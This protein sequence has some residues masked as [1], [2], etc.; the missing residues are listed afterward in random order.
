M[1]RRLGATRFVIGLL[2]AAS[3]AFAVDAAA[4]VVPAA[5]LSINSPSV[6]EGDSGSTNLTFTV[7]LDPTSASQVT[8]D[9]ADA[10]T[11]TATSGTDYTALTAGTLTFAAGVSSQ[12]ITVSVTGDTTHES[13]ETVE[14]T[15]SN[16]TNAT[17]STTAGTG[18]GTIRDDENPT[19]TVNSPTVTEGDSGSTNMTFTVSLSPASRQRVRVVFGITG[20]TA[21]CGTDYT[22]TLNCSQPRVRMTFNPGETSRTVTLAVQGDTTA[23]A[24]EETVL[25][26]LSG[27]SFGARIGTGTGTGTITDDDQP[28]L[29]LNSPS[30]TEG[31]SGSTDMTFTV[32]MSAASTAQVTVGYTD[33]GGTAT[34]TSGTDYEALS[35]G[36]LTFAPGETSKTITVK[37]TGDTDPE[38]DE[39]VRVALSQTAVTNAVVPASGRLGV[40]TITDD[41]LA[42]LRTGPASVTEGDSGSVSLTFTVTLVAAS[43]AQVT[44][45]YADAGT[46][47][48]TSGTDYT[49]V[50]AGTLTIAAG[51][52]SGTITVSVTG[53]TEAETPETVVL[54]LSNPTNARFLTPSMATMT[55][56]IRDDDNFP[57]SNAGPDQTVN[58]GDTVNLSGSGSDPD[59]T[60][61]TYEW[62]QTDGPVVTLTGATTTTPS[63]TA[64]TGLT[65]DTVLRF[66]LVVTSNF[67]GTSDSVDITVD[68]A[69]AS[70]TASAGTDQTVNEGDTVNLSGTGPTLQGVGQ[71]RFSWR[72]TGGGSSTVSLTRAD[73]ARPTFTAPNLLADD[74]LTITLTVTVGDDTVTDT[75]DVTVR[76]DNDPP[77]AD[78]GS[79]RLAYG[80]TQVNLQGSGSDPEGETLSYSWSQTAGEPTV[81]LTGATTATPSFIAPLI[82]SETTL[83]FMLT[84]TAGGQ[85]ATDTVNVRLL[86]GPM[87]DAGANQT[88]AESD[89]VSLD[90]RGSTAPPGESL[91][92]SWSQTGGSPAVSLTGGT[93][94]T[95]SFTAP[96]GLSAD[97]TLTF[98]LTVTL[99]SGA[100]S[101][102]DTVE[103]T[104]TAA[105]VFTPPP[106]VADAG[107]DQTVQGGQLVT[108]D[109]SGSTE[110][111]SYSWSQ[112]GGGPPVT[113]TNVITATPSFVAPLGLPDDITLTFTLT[114]TG[115]TGS[116]TDTVDVTVLGGPIFT[117]IPLTADAGPDQTVD[118]GDAV[119]L[120]GS[121]STAPE[122]ETLSYSWSQTGGSPTVTLTGETT[123][124]PSF[125]APDLT[126]DATLTFTL[127]VTVGAESA[128][129]TV[130]VTVSA[131]PVIADAGPDQTVDEGDAVSLDGSGSTA[132]PGEALSYAWRQTGGSP[133]VTLTGETTATPSFTA[134]NLTADATLTFTLT[135]TAGADNATDTVAVMVQADNDAPTANAG[136]D[137][138]VYEGDSVNLSG[139]GSDPEGEALS[140]AWSQTNGDPTVTLTDATT[141]TPSFTAP[142]VSADVTLTFTLTVTAGGD[143][144]TDTVDVAIS[145]FPTLSID[146]SSVAEGDADSTSLT[147]TVSLSAESGRQVTVAYATADGTA[148]AGSDYQAASGEVQ[149]TPGDTELTV[150][151]PV[152]GDTTPEA[153]ETFTL[154]LSSPV[155]AELSRAQ[156]TA[157]IV[158]DDTAQASVADARAEEGD[159]G[160]RNIDF[161]VTLSTASDIQVTVAYATADG[162]A[163][164]GTDYRATNG[165]L[166]FAPGET[167]LTVSVPVLGDTTPEGDETFTLALSGATNAELGRAATGVIVDDDM[168]EARDRALEASLAGFGRTLTWDAM[169][170]ISG[171]F[172]ETP[173]AGGS[174]MTLGG[175]AAPIGGNLF[176]NQFADERMAPWASEAGWS[177]TVQAPG[178]AG[179]HHSTEPD[180]HG[181][182][183]GQL[184]LRDFL[185]RSSFDLALAGSDEG[186]EG[187]HLS[188]WG[189]ASSGRFSGEPAAGL[190]SDGEVATGYL[191]LDAKV[192]ERLLAGVALAHSD[193]EMGYGISD[194]GGKLDVSLTS[195]L[196]Y[197]HFQ[198]SEELEIWS[199]VGLGW[200]DGAF[201]DAVQVG[202][203]AQHDTRG[204]LD[205]GFSMAA[206]GA[207]RALAP[208]RNVDLELKSD[209]FV[210]FMEGDPEGNAAQPEV[211]ARSQGLRLTLAGRQE[212]M[213]SEQGRLGV[214]VEFGGRWDGGDAQTGW[215]AEIGGGLDYRHADLGLQVAVRGQYLLVHSARSFDEKGVSVTLE[216]D[217]GVQG[218]GLSLALRPAWGANPSGAAAMWNNEALLRHGGTAPHTESGAASE[219]LDLEWGYGFGL[220]E[221]AGLLRLRGALSNQGM[222]Q[223]GYRF[224]GVLDLS[225][226]TRASLELNRLEGLGK[227]SHGLL[228]EW[229]HTW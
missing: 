160:T 219:R 14:I 191:G 209:A 228:I 43:G 159:S 194:F 71:P 27:V 216:F 10:G 39:T 38:A 182:G 178:F 64:P 59:G 120:D 75:V 23:E 129:D 95:P 189:R 158:N 124:T 207:N 63:F 197:V 163:S 171:R 21:T 22:T 61:V 100:D 18:T 183:R 126:E 110:A 31:D 192:G 99:G 146:S 202:Q 105:T 195:V 134:P 114:V 54:T 111:L 66:S 198:L 164:A 201:R 196:P 180:L 173:A 211:K 122:G 103:V 69:T 227:P 7:T 70:W 62:H 148:R 166:Q 168:A 222:G 133:T 157:T 48:A 15:L 132:R 40:G 138:M 153:D 98:T 174:Q 88:V 56:T 92:Y 16:P 108:L 20:G 121:G 77:A 213:A 210:M 130:D 101:D 162:T 76:A 199:M 30:V 229:Q 26:A 221:G 165:E 118:G 46:G 5:T 87:A 185:Q 35:Q 190:S 52:A 116:A 51:D 147:F 184:S 167:E 135:V 83:T 117:P 19:F 6:N 107:P 78:A 109:G 25:V 73:T 226:R 84:V 97:V 112:T 34:A 152:L 80:G 79:D 139:R 9:Y 82:Q 74:T 47:T 161:N 125:T 11:G 89:A 186:D 68:A 86:I 119:S 155:N 90:G 172:R 102:T 170:A 53:D 67:E 145:A 169:S 93:T 65:A 96:S 142:S 220:R 140:Y 214:N 187:R 143:S 17:I 32:T 113:L 36:T 37:V 115:F 4:Q 156:A 224:G 29:S 57:V 41:D 215:G 12:T 131:I 13:H 225:E 81:T 128:T 193:G 200:G 123:A 42:R 8:V 149:F 72:H 208:W 181:P 177:P 55:G 94:A 91:R 106:L 188:L 205:L 223:R 175:S 104:V 141:A 60:P 154:T 137:Q 127:T 2:T 28:N 3:L 144:A 136:A 44:V 150:S 58:E 203:T 33:A 151:V 85:T 206:V 179:L 1:V 24:S 204:Q 50:T 218:Q 45:D 217:P 49:A 212:L 176:G